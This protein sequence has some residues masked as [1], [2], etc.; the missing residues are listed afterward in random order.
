MSPDGAGAGEADL[1]VVVLLLLSGR[2]PEVAAATGRL[3]VLSGHWAN[4]DADEDRGLTPNEAETPGGEAQGHDLR[5]VA[6]AFMVAV[7]AEAGHYGLA[8]KQSIGTH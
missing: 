4:L 8:G 3:E 7:L 6:V 1:Q 5:R 2:L